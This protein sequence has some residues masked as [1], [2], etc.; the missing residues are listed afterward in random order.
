[1]CHQKF[2][3]DW[4][5]IQIENNGDMVAHYILG[6]FLGASPDEQHQQDE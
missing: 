4:L 5:E 1:M 3:V 6:T 2:I